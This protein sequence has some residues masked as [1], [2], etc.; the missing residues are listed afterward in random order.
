MDEVLLPST[1]QSLVPGCGTSTRVE[2]RLVVVLVLAAPGT[3]SNGRIKEVPGA[4][5]RPEP[6]GWPRSQECS[7]V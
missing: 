7:G 5:D 6:G 4:I 2:G 3:A 1:C